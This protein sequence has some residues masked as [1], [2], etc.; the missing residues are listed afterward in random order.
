VDAAGEFHGRFMEP[1]L[2]L[3][4][5]LVR[6]LRAFE[7]LSGNLFKELRDALLL[8]AGGL[9]QLG[10]EMRGEVPAIDLGLHAPH[11]KASG[12][13]A[14]EIYTRRTCSPARCRCRERS[15]IACKNPSRSFGET[16]SARPLS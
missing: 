1:L 6:N 16:S 4:F 15:T 12:A 2:T 3:L 13:L 14:Q 11:C 10:L 7:P 9:L 8:G 5:V